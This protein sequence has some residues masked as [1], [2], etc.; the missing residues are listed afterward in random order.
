VV[1]VNFTRILFLPFFG[2]KWSIR[3]F[4]AEALKLPRT[5]YEKN[6]LIDEMCVSLQWAAARH[7]DK[8][9]RNRKK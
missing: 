3:K 9:I 6:E 1:L 7:R 5:D 8:T 2:R 4:A